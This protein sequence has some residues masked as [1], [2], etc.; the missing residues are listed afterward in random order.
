MA[1]KPTLVDLDFG[2]IATGINVK[3]PV[4]TGDIANK[5]YVDDLIE[6][7]AW[8]DDV[9]A[10][11][12]A[13]VNI[14][15]AP[16]TIDGVTLVV[17]DRVLLKD[18]TAALENGIYVFAGTG[19]AMTRAP[20][21]DLM[22]ELSNAVTT[23]AGGTANAGTTF[24]QTT[25]TGTVGTD[26]IAWT[27]FGAVVPL[28]STTVAGKIRIATQTEVNAGTLADVAV[29]PQ[30]LN[31]WSGNVGRF[32]QTFGDGVA[33]SYVLTHNLGTLDVIV[34]VREVATNNTV[35][36]ADSRQ[37]IN[38]VVINLN[39]APAAN[40]LRAVILA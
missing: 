7:L 20:D 34:T 14:A 6:G 23:V 11:S 25:T 12:T 15:A 19:A 13:N 24:R 18:Q 28:A 17:G 39:T 38:N 4:A 32:A 40:S 10:A 2:N 35:I 30:T 31:N 37:D 8:K 27:N 5:K 29:T 3:A 22:T 26:P 1:V 9:A 16:A 21:A 36:V 33:T